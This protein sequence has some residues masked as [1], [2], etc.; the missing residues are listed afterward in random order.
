MG[1]VHITHLPGNIDFFMWL[2]DDLT[3]VMDD[4]GLGSVILLP[5]A[6]LTALSPVTK[7]WLCLWQNSQC[8]NV[9]YHLCLPLIVYS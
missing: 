8:C 4:V 2:F 7:T 1:K 9:I 6:K 3:Q 5:Q